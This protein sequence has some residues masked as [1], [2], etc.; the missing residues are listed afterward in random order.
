[1]LQ[2]RK[3]DDGK[4]YAIKVVQKTY[5]FDTA[6]RL[7]RVL[8]ERR[9]L[10]KV[11]GHP[12]I[13]ELFWAFQ[14]VSQLFLVLEFCPGGELFF[15]LQRNGKFNE[16]AARFYFVEILLGLEYLHEQGILYRDLK[17]ENVLLDLDGHIRLTDFGLSKDTLQGSQLFS[18]FCGTWG[19]L[20]PEM[21]EKQGHSKS[22]DYYCLGCLLM[23]MLTGELPCEDAGDTQDMFDARCTIDPKDFKFRQP[24]SPAAKSLIV[25]MLSRDPKQR[26]GSTGA[27]EVKKHEWLQDVDWAAFSQKAVK[28][29]IEPITRQQL[30]DTQFTQQD[31]TRVTQTVQRF[32]RPHVAMWSELGADPRDIAAAQASK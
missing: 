12:F 23:L 8:A 26:L 20:P 7:E 5:A 10:N 16:A 2:A 21:I 22:L 13:V 30:F 24:V 1:V 32:S 4:L 17:P 18:S 28:A 3:K 6:K 11:K 27:A 29:P 14:S 19:Y 31:P 9:I 15:H 25:A